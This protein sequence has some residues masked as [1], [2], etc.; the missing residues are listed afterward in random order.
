MPEHIAGVALTNLASSS[1][2]RRHFFFIGILSVFLLNFAVGWTRE[3]DRVV[4]SAALVALL[5]TSLGEAGVL[6]AR[7]DQRVHQRRWFF[8]MGSGAAVVFMAWR[9]QRLGSLIHGS[10][11]FLA[12]APQMKLSRRFR[13]ILFSRQNMRETDLQKLLLVPTDE[14]YNAATTVAGASEL[15]ETNTRTGFFDRMDDYFSNNI[16]PSRLLEASFATPLVAKDDVNQL[17]PPIMSDVVLVI[18][19]GVLQEFI[20]Q[21]PFEHLFVANANSNFAR[22]EWVKALDLAREN[23]PSL[24]RDP[25]WSLEKL[26]TLNMDLGALFDAVSIDDPATGYPLFRCLRFQSPF[27]SLESVGTLQ[28]TTGPYIRRM[29]KLHE[30]LTSIQHPSTRRNL[31]PAYVFVGYSRGALLALDVLARA[32]RQDKTSRKTPWLQ[33]VRGMVSIGGPIFGAEGADFANSP[34][35]L[36]HTV[37]NPIRTFGQKLDFEHEGDAGSFGHAKEIFKNS[38]EFLKLGLNLAQMNRTKLSERA[39]HAASLFQQETDEAGVPLPKASIVTDWFRRLLFER[40][41]LHKP[42]GE[43][44]ENIK[45]VKILVAALI[46]SVQDLSSESRTAWWS[47]P[48]N[49]I[50]SN[51]PFFSIPATMP[52]AG[53]PIENLENSIL[54]AR[55][56]SSIDWWCNR[57]FYYAS[58]GDTGKQCQDGQVSCDRAVF[59]PFLLESMNS[60]YRNRETGILAVLGSHHWGIALPFVLDGDA[61]MSPGSSLDDIPRSAIL[62]A[63]GAM[64]VLRER[65]Q[66]TWSWS[67]L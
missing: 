51:V 61:K 18:F 12:H 45:R 19:G 44:Y 39:A 63:L 29:T 55:S 56:G 9:A 21:G 43:Y 25:V 52:G 26:S 60:K 3:V 4:V 32:T 34:G 53:E 30:I 10:S 24:A 46:E 28:S 64:F 41:K 6:V 59:W 62:D 20:D 17:E 50:S 8:V 31:N 49:Y 65:E 38:I 36:F 54:Y 42:V 57:M 23:N 7:V 48:Q 14:F 13:N 16:I 40:F 66:Q 47:D 5:V 15:P 67:E 33:Q 37:L 1:Y 27:G 22:V 11:F 2:T 35:H 58:Y